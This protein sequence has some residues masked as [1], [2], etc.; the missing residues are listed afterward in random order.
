M[1]W[2]FS[3]ATGG[4]YPSD[5]LDEYPN[6]PADLVDVSG[7][8]KAELLQAEAGGGK[9]S[10]QT[11]MATRWRSTGPLQVT[12]ILLLVR[13]RFETNCFVRLTGRNYRMCRRQQG[14]AMWSIARSCAIARSSPAGR[15]RLVGR[16]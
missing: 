9:S 15:G 10:S 8:R 13:V 11:P 5:S 2:K 14:S 4:F 12:R 3:S 6:L 16:F 7:S 1:D